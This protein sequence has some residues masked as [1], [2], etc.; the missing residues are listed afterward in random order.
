MMNLKKHSNLLFLTYF[1]FT[2]FGFTFFFKT[3]LEKKKTIE[4]LNHEKIVAYEKFE[5]VKEYF[6]SNYYFEGV[7]LNDK[8]SFRA[9]DSSIIK[10][11]SLVKDSPKLF[12]FNNAINCEVCIDKLV[13]DFS[14]F[15]DSFKKEDI[16]VFGSYKQERDILILKQ[17]Y[18]ELFENTFNLNN[19]NFDNPFSNINIPVMFVVDSSLKVNCVF[20]ADK[21][22]S[23]LNNQ[24]LNVIFNR[25]FR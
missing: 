23:D 16:I 20:L 10:V 3:L 13:N 6:I 18:G 12:I 7:Y 1:I 4:Y 14:S 17:T 25:Y 5:N 15:R 9:R 2:L 22:I 19:C 24:Y 11:S 8:S 21:S